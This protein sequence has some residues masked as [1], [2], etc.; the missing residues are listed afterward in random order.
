MSEH[1]ISGLMDSSLD[2][3]KKLVDVNSVIGD[4]IHTPDGTTIIPISKVSFGFAAGGSDLPT[5]KPGDLFGGGSGGGVSINPL[6]FLIVKGDSVRIVHIM[7]ADSTVEKVAG[8][9]PDVIDQI[10]GL[11][12]GKKEKADSP[13]QSAEP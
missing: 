10:S 2:N 12:K 3:L 8:M 6:A 9:V 1:P 4:P 13:D 5:A 11:F 7:E